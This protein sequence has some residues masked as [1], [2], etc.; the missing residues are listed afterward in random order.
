MKRRVLITGAT[1][2]V[3]KQVLESLK[4]IN[5]SITLVMRSKSSKLYRH[6]SN[7][8]SVI[9]TDDLF[10]ETEGWWT[11]KLDGID[12]VIHLA[13]FV[14]PG[15]YLYSSKNI[16]CFNG[17]LILAKAA[18]AAGVKKFVGIGTCF[19]YDL[20]GAEK[21]SV[22]TPLNP[23]TP[24]AA[25]KAGLFMF[26]S[27]WLENENVEFAWCRLF[28]LYGEGEDKRRLVP[29]LREKI[30]RGEKVELTSGTQ[31]RDFLDVKVAGSMIAQIAL[32]KLT[33]PHNIC[34]EIPVSVREMAERIADEYDRRDLLIFNSR[35]DN[36]FDPPHVVGMKN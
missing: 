16:E 8:V 2:F 14:E 23:L 25:A 1:G 30:S 31:V 26:L 17:T 27:Q 21:L 36:E 5:V 3:G 35:P 4:D 10:S 20:L 24:Y 22:E 19:E 32:S 34:S 18:A 9:E 15:K 12:L 11:D 6:Q 28:Y 29:Y 13:W 7:V 33:G